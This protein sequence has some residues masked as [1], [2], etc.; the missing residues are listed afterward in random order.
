MDAN[1]ESLD[2]DTV[3]LRAEGGGGGG[4]KV[5]LWASIQKPNDPWIVGERSG[6][7]LYHSLSI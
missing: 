4:K 5:K 2:R 7:M 1:D 3:I 6:D